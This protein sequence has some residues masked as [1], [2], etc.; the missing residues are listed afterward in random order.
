MHFWQI[1]QTTAG[2]GGS[3]YWLVLVFIF[4][5]AV[6]FILAPAERTGIR[7]AV[8]LLAMLTLNAP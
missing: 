5:A 2:V 4:V 8:L 6:L 3:L 7:S 1:V